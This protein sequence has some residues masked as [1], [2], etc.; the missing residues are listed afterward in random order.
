M[1]QPL[2]PAFTGISPWT[3]STTR[4]IRLECSS[5]A[6]D[7]QRVAAL[8]QVKV[9]QPGQALLVHLAGGV[10]GRDDGRNAAPDHV[11]AL[12]RLLFL[13]DMAGSACRHC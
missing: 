9:D 4:R 3:P 12:A 5:R 11:R 13:L 8:V 2:L 1:Q 10:H 7:Q 6:G